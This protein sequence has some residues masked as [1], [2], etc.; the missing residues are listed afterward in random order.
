ML[1]IATNLSNC[2]IK[3][4][5]EQLLPH[6]S[7]L[8]NLHHYGWRKNRNYLKP[9]I[10][11]FG[12]IM[13]CISTNGEEKFTQFLNEINNFN[14]NFNYFSHKISPYINSLILN[15]ILQHATTY[16]DLY[17]KTINGY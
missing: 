5:R 8:L 15:V 10:T 1:K 7:H 14:R 17:I 4:C 3:K 9:W 13:F 11:S 2:K 12:F 6:N 16:P